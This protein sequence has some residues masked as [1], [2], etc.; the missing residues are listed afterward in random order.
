MCYRCPRGTPFSLPALPILLTG[1]SIVFHPKCHG[2]TK[3]HVAR[4]AMMMCNQHSCSM[5]FR[6]TGDAGGMLF[7]YV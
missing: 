3:A 5:C 4:T 2:V 6:N 1:L 7:R